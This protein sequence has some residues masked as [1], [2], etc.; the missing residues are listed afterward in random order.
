MDARNRLA[1]AELERRWNEKLEEIGAVKERLSC[2]DAKRHSLSTE[3]EAQ[4]RLMGEDFAEVWQDDRCPPTLKKMIFRTAMEE[5]VVHA[6]SDKKTLEFTIHWKGG[7]HTQLL[8]DRPRPATETA[9]PVEALEITRRMAVRN[10]DAAPTVADRID[11]SG[12]RDNGRMRLGK[13][14][15]RFAICPIAGE[16]CKLRVIEAHH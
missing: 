2:L 13:A 16:G 7:V 15:R 9:T 1:A 12:E 5:I 8:M 3:E 14:R 6:D 11:V 10:G 4:I